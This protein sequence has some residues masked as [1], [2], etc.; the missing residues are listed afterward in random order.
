MSATPTGS[1][2]HARPS[3]GGHGSRDIGELRLRR[4]E[5]QRRRGLMRL[6]VG[7]GVLAGIVLL[8]VTPGV[9]FAAIVALLVLAVCVASVAIE[10]RRARRRRATSTTLPP[11]A[12]R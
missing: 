5:A 6:D 8:L 7:L 11:R 2:P 9:A 12:E 10:R 4:R 1:D 3:G